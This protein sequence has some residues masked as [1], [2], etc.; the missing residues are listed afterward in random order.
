MNNMIEYFKYEDKEIRT[1]IKNNEVW[2]AVRDICN[3][4]GISKTSTVVER[5]DEDECGKTAVMDSQNRLQEIYI[6]SESGLY[7][8]VI[9]SNKSDA[10]K[11]Q[12]WITKEVLPSIRKHGM[13]AKDELLNN[14]EL[15]L[16]V[17]Q[18][19]IDEKNKVLQLETKLEEQKPKVEI[20]DEVI[21]QSGLL[22]FKQLSEIFGRYSRTKLFKL[23]REEHILSNNKPN[24]NLPYSKYQKYFKVKVTP[25]RTNNG[26]K[27]ICT[28]LCT[29]D[30]IPF[31]KQ[32][33]DKKKDL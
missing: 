33:L 4:L 31:I 29:M 26:M 22:N 25:R 23:L 2:F 1:V 24:W 19:L 16:D 8:A 7:E 6:I 18:K 3:A 17:A 12:K 30:S 27:E 20:Y 9:R 5:L 10:K 15:L 11:F 14:P 21:N 13:Y 28:T 32:V